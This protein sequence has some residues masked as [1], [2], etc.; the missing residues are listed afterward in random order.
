MTSFKYRRGTTYKSRFPTAPSLTAQPGRV[1]LIQK[2]FEHD[3][4]ILDYPQSSTLWFSVLKTGT[5][6]IFSWTQGGKTSTW[7]GYVSS[8]SKTSAA[9]RS[10]PMKVYCI[11]T[12]YV[13]KARA[14]RVF[15]NVSVTDVA[16]KIAKQFNLSF[17]GENS[18]RK[19]DQLTMTGQS[20]WQWL[21]EQAARIGYS[22]YVRNTTIYMRPMDKVINSGMSYAPTLSLTPPLN[23]AGSGVS[24]RTL[25]RFRILNGD[26]IE[27][28]STPNTVKITSGVNPLTGKAVSSSESPKRSG[29]KLRSKPNTALF[30]DY[31]SEVVHGSSFSKKAAKDLAE[32]ARFTIPAKISGQGDPRITPY[33][34][35]YVEGTGSDTDGY[36]LVKECKHIFLIT[37]EYQFEATVVTDGIGSNVRTPFR[38]SKPN[39]DGTINIEEQILRGLSQ[40][41]NK[42]GRTKLVQKVPSTTET[43]QGFSQLGSLWSGR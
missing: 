4:L 8:V 43:Q 11:G 13:L 42:P 10:R 36:W 3:I 15:R 5:P 41:N 14:N 17:V 23:P 1:E 39:R 16:R 35:V 40:A 21:Q 29:Q 30:R 34:I 2:Q 26:L 6:V 20:Y 37:A 38:A 22:L 24:E 33:N 12:S 32:A 19:F 31:S 7:T 9:E 18:S 28:G 27:D 25:D